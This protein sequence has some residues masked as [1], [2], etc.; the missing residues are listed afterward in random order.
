MRFTSFVRASVARIA[1]L[2][3]LFLFA[4]SSGFAQVK[5]DLLWLHAGHGNNINALAFSPDGSTIA[6][7]SLADT[8]VKL[9]NATDGKFQKTLIFGLGVFSLAYSPNGQTLALGGIDNNV[10]LVRASDGVVLQTLKGHTSLVLTVAFSADGKMLA[11][12]SQD[13]T[14]KVW[15]VA[16]GALIRTY[17]GHTDRVTSVSF[18]PD[19]TAVASGSNDKTV[20]VWKVSDG[21]LLHSLTDSTTAITT[22]A[23]SPDGTVIAAASGD[24]TRLWRVSDWMLQWTQSSGRGGLVFAPNGHT[25]ATSNSDNTIKIWNTADGSVAQTLTGHTA[26]PRWLAFSPDGQKVA[27]AANKESFRIWKVADGTVL[28]TPADYAGNVKSVAYTP[29]DLVLTGG[30]DSVKEWNAGDG[31]VKSIFP[32]SVNALALSPDGQTFVTE[33]SSPLNVA[34]GVRIFNVSDGLLVANLSA[35]S[36]QA[37]AFSP[38]GTIV[39]SAENGTYI[40]LIRV[41]DNTYLGSML[42]NSASFI[43]AIAFSPD[44]KT[45]ASVG[46]GGIKLWKVS[47]QSLITTLS[48]DNTACALFLPDGKTLLTGYDGITFWDIATGMPQATWRVP[49]PIPFVGALALSPDGTTLAAGGST[50]SLWRIADGKLLV[51]YDGETFYTTSVAFSPDSSNLAYGRFDGFAAL[52]HLPTNQ[53][54]T[55]TTISSDSTTSYAGAAGQSL[56]FKGLL[57]RSS[58]NAGL[59]SRSLVFLVD[60]L[61]VG[62]S[63]TISSGST[64][65]R[66]TLPNDISL[67]DHVLG[68][69]FNGDSSYLSSQVVGTLRIVQPTVVTVAAKTGGIGQTVSLTARL[70]SGT[71]AMNGRT[72]TFKVNGSTV[73]TGTTDTNGN[74]SVNYVIPE[75]LGLVTAK[76]T[77]EFA[78]DSAYAAGSGTGSLKVGRG[79]TAFSTF[80]AQGKAGKPVTLTVRLRAGTLLVTGR[81]VTFQIGTTSGTATTGSDGLAK[82]VYTIPANQPVGTITY[83][84]SFAGDTLY[85]P[86]TGTGSLKV[87]P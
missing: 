16:T 62:S 39:A 38:D 65:F 33:G 4:R 74:A 2:A 67:G 44:G 59:G 23:F 13:K 37:V 45:L 54:A 36:G 26:L 72:L 28:L 64:W 42:D 76:I 48:T 80:S 81:T 3:L 82:F 1:F 18:A 46:Q 19:G 50:L 5:P 52:A 41:S 29:D 84:L 49:N 32:Y 25:L 56:R 86:A 7:V 47:D 63:Q 75:S 85:K 43:S 61:A 10:T 58:D 11:S 21:S 57:R 12:G 79:V 60:G 34:S 73:G 31:T 27:S 20:Q 78:G 77:A 51:A 83:H 66:Y 87:V 30:P 6:S 22:A 53:A 68:V 15:N 55:K 24:G 70:L 17:K 9:W 71:L 35:L 14:A 40:D 8:T 69:A